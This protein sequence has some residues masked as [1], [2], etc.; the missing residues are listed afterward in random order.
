MSN[1]EDIFILFRKTFRPQRAR[2]IYIDRFG[3]AMQS[4]TW[5]QTIPL[6][7]ILVLEVIC[8]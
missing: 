2:Y 8:N 3:F 1:N 7:N 6:E 5:C 4:I